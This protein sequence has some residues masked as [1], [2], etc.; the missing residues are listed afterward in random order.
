MD[1][2]L[3]DGK[4]IIAGPCSAENKQQ[5]ITSAQNAKERNLSA[6]RLSL[7]KPR[8]KPGFEG[9]GLDGIDWLSEASFAGIPVA[10]EVLSA[11]NVYQLTRTLFAQNERATLIIWIGSRNQNHL[12]QKEIAKAACMDNRVFLLIKNQPWA[13]MQHW[14]GIHEHVISTGFPKERL[15]HVHRGFY[16]YKKE[17]PKNYRNMP[18]YDMAMKVKKETSCKML[19]DPSHIGGS[20]ENVKSVVNESLHYGFDG[21]M[22]EAHP[23]PYVAITDR[24]Q[25]LSFSEL[26]SIL[27]LIR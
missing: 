16:P 2:L 26:D 14:L 24:D 8:T 18:D 22:I 23:D 3:R 15:I 20:V 13:D 4:I 25:Q 1:T 5:V 12:V 9:V 17:N 6:V 7:W 10:T 21:Y 19:L 11:Q 27:P